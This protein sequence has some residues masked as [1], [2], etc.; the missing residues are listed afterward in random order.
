M[1][2]LRERLV[3]RDR[4]VCRQKCRPFGPPRGF[5]GTLFR[6]LTDP[7]YQRGGPLGLNIDGGV[8]IRM[9]G[10]GGDGDE[11]TRSQEDIFGV[12]GD[13]EF[14]E[15][16]EEF[17]LEGLFVVVLFL[18]ENVVDDVGVGGFAHGEGGI[19]VL[20]LEIRVEGFAGEAGGVTFEGGG[21]DRRWRAWAGGSSRGGHGRR[22]RRW[23]GVWNGR[24][25]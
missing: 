23:R 10:I 24:I 20:P 19:A 17:F 8:G 18:V 12:V 7:G 25:R 3:E 4:E 9:R 22:F 11:M 14:F 21:R 16:F 1:G 5:W 6:G 13:L 15:E 2:C